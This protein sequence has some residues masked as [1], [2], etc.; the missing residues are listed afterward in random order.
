MIKVGLGQAE[1]LDTQRAIQDAISHCRQQLE[2]YEPQ[3]GIVFAGVEF[4]HRQ[5]LDEINRNFPEIDLIGCTTAGEF[6]SS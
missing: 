1:G 4:N 6:S 5:M 2:G 3:A